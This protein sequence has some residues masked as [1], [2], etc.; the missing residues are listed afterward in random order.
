MIRKT[1]L[2]ISLLLLVGT[3]GLWVRSTRDSCGESGEP[4]HGHGEIWRPHVPSDVGCCAARAGI[5]NG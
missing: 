5:I 1:L 2:V 4:D 3:V